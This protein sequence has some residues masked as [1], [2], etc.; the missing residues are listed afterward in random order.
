MAS[1]TGSAQWVPGQ[2][3]GAARFVLERLLGQ[4]GMGMVWLARDERFGKCV[5]LKFVPALVQSDVE[6]LASL[7]KE[8]MCAR[9][10]T[11]THIVRIHDLH[12]APGEAAFISMEYVEGKSLHQLCWEQPGGVFAWDSLVPWVKQLCDAL[13]YAHGEGVIHRD[14]KP[15]NLMVDGRG[16]LKLADFGIAAVVSDSLSRISVK[17]DSSGT[18]AYMSPQQ[19]CGKKP[20][21]ED[22]VY[23]LG[24]TLYHLLTSKPPFY[25]GLI[26]YQ[27]S[28]VA[29][30]SIPARLREFEITNDVPPPVCAV[31]MA[32]LEKEREKRPST[33]QAVWEQIEKAEGR[34]QKAEVGEQKLGSGSQE[35]EGKSGAGVPPASIPLAAPPTVAA[36][37]A[38]VIPVTIP[39]SQSEVIPATIAAEPSP[40]IPATIPATRAE[41]PPT[42]AARLDELD[43]LAP[44]AEAVPVTIAARTTEIGEASQGARVSDPPGGAGEVSEVPRTVGVPEVNKAKRVGRPALLWAGVIALL[45]LLAVGGWYFGKHL[46]EQRRQQAGQQS[47]AA[48]QQ[49]AEKL[50]RETA[51]AQRLAGAKQ[52]GEAERQRL[53]EEKAKLEAALL[54][55]QQEAKAQEEARRK[56]E[57]EA[58]ALAEEKRKAEEAQKQKA[59]AE[60]KAREEEAKRKAE[61]DARLKALAE[62]KAKD[63]A[64]KQKA[65]P[66]LGARWTNSLGMAFAPVPGTKVL[67]GIWDVRVQDYAVYAAANP[68]VDAAWK[69][70]EWEGVPVS[71]GPEHPV[72]MV[73]WE[74]AKAFCAWLTKKE[75][76]EGELAAGQVYRLPTDAEWSDA[77][78]I[79]DKE[80]NG[81]PS[82]KSGKLEGV[83]PWG[84]QWPPPKGAGNYADM[85]SRQK[86][87]EKWTFIEGY[88]DGYATT[89]PVG[90]YKANPYGLYDMGGNVWQWCEDWYDTDQKYR[91]LRGGSWINV[92]SRYLLSSNRV[93]NTPVNRFNYYGF[94]LVVA[95]GVSAR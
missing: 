87:G 11:H 28:Q 60:Q 18:P 65:G 21:P 95:V 6:A 62:Q 89:S 27:V 91:V 76:G 25:A 61:E 42:V 36:S 39:A 35:L 20:R 81:T 59:L 38:E 56:A 40:T 85:T 80:G 19:M 17:H 82:D 57:A 67:F 7:R 58:A 4:G 16:R 5:A 9:E 93:S 34:R 1:P 31:V 94:R 32:C 22:D 70:V 12:E 41:L 63:E 23:A 29:P 77:V 75:Q 45:A 68:G 74:D 86:F 83:Y 84:N 54:K 92:V 71:N 24:A 78:G 53:A 30:D 69:K 3:V 73:S 51:E 10:L 14:L 52:Q 48:D 88:D 43:Q 66:Q 50:A 26:P 49:A 44:G 13:T 79:G 37:P 90:S 2:Q 55:S 33:V 8:T 46:P 15:A 64:A 72:T 47:S